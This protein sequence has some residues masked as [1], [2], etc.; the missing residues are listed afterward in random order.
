MSEIIN[1]VAASGL[2]T[3]NLE[4]IYP[5][6]KRMSVD[7]AAQLWQGIALKEKDFRD[8]IK[9]HDWEQYRDAYVAVYCSADAIIPHWAFMLV[10]SA[11]SGIARRAVVASPPELESLIFRDLIFS[12]DPEVYRDARVVI[13][14]CSDREV[15][16]SAYSDLVF[17]LQPVV[18]SLMFGEPCSTV[19]VF[20]RAVTK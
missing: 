1:K 2:V 14:G 19:P 9:L 10:V 3:I 15:P 17:H 18:K 20:K 5:E 6:G 8:W 4:E 7:I 11:L 13:K 12:L 16:V